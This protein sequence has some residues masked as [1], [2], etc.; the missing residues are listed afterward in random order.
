MFIVIG[1]NGLNELLESQFGE[2]EGLINQIFFKKSMGIGI[3]RDGCILGF[4]L[5]KSLS[6]GEQESVE[7]VE[8]L[9][10]GVCS[11]S[12]QLCD[13]FECLLDHNDKIRSSSMSFKQ[14]REILFAIFEDGRSDQMHLLLFEHIDQLHL[15]LDG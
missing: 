4:L 11:T 15:L 5:L 13:F 10:S 14:M 9:R 7:A 1:R 12:Q 2:L 3:K 8:Y 6:I